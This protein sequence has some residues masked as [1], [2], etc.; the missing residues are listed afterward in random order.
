MNQRVQIPMIIGM[1]CTDLPGALGQEHVLFGLGFMND[2]HRPPIVTVNPH[3]KM[4]VFESV[5]VLMA[6]QIF[7]GSSTKLTG[8]S[9]PTVTPSVPQTPV[10]QTPKSNYQW[11]PKRQ[12]SAGV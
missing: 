2:R 1:T 6:H 7:H 8:P 12:F 3:D 11:P 10:P 9:T 5:M 4:S